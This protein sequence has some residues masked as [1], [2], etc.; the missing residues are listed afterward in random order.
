MG[1][2]SWGFKTSVSSGVC[3]AESGASASEALEKICLLNKI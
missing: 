3:D 2:G 1:F